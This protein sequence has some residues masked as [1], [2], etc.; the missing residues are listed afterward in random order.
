[1]RMAQDCAWSK[2]IIAAA[3]DGELDWQISSTNT[4]SIVVLHNLNDFESSTN[5]SKSYRTSL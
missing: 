4:G 3:V 5:A 1:M 2:D